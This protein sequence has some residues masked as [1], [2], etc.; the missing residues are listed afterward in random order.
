MATLV[1]DEFR[2][3]QMGNPTHTA[4]DFN[5]PDDIRIAL[6]DNL[7]F[8]IA[9]GTV[10]WAEASAALVGSMVALA[11]ESVTNPGIF[12]ADDATISSVTGNPIEQLAVLKFSGT[13]ST[14]PISHAYDSVTVGI[15]LTPNGGD[16]TVTWAGGGILQI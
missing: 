9:A 3:A 6:V 13:A 14:S 16:V 2:N 15:P 12:D 10:D 11:A 7:T 5:T 4:W 8:T 1:T